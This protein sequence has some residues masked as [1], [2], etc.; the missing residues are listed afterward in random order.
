MSAWASDIKVALEGENNSNN[1][2]NNAS[3]TFTNTGIPYSNTIYHDG[4]YSFGRW[5]EAGDTLVGDQ[6][7]T[8]SIKTC[9]FLSYTPT[10]SYSRFSPFFMRKASWGYQVLD[11]FSGALYLY[12]DYYNTFVTTTLTLDAWVNFSITWDGTNCKLYKNNAY[13]G[14]VSWTQAVD[15]FVFKPGSPDVA[16]FANCNGYIDNFILSTNVYT[17][18]PIEPLAGSYGFNGLLQMGA[19]PIGGVRI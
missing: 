7:I 1:T 9:D 2:G 4:V 16:P 14:Q 12:N 5:V 19:I 17:S 13:I 10:G 6:A 15:S 3:W 8:D 18:F 11:E